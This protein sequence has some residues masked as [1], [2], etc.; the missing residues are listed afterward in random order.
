VQKRRIVMRFVSTR[1]FITLVALTAFLAGC[2]TAPEVSYIPDLADPSSTT[3]LVRQTPSHYVR[4]TSLEFSAGFK[5]YNPDGMGVFLYIKNNSDQVVRIDPV[6]F[7][8]IGFLNGEPTPLPV[9]NPD[10]YLTQRR[11]L[12]TVQRVANALSKYPQRDSVLE[13]PV[14]ELERTLLQTQDLLPGQQIEGLLL[15]KRL[16]DTVKVKAGTRGETVEQQV[17]QEFDKYQLTVGLAGSHYMIQF[18][19]TV[20]EPK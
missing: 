17:E 7:Q 8:C 20:V 14:K 1:G 9:L 2:A 12:L 19:R 5:K 13:M 18:S 10:D 11:N 16:Y 15:V 4:S 3:V 6:D